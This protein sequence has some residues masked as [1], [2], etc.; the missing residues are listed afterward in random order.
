MKWH[1]FLEDYPYPYG[2]NWYSGICL[3]HGL[4]KT[5]FQK[6]AKHST[7]TLSR[8]YILCS[9]NP[10]RVPVCERDSTKSDNLDVIKHTLQNHATLFIL[11]WSLLWWRICLLKVLSN[12]LLAFFN[13]RSL[14]ASRQ[15]LMIVEAIIHES[16]TAGIPSSINEC[17]HEIQITLHA[18]VRCRD[19]LRICW[20]II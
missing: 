2:T 18:G 7:R 19:V 5:Y 4:L 3:R 1:W 17:E 20:S 11:Q 16:Q 6:H 13:L 8:Y 10:E 14:V 15:Y 12:S 9:K